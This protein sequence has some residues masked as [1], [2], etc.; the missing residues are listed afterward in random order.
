MNWQKF[1][2]GDVGLLR[3]QKRK[4]IYSESKIIPNVL[5][6]LILPNKNNKKTKAIRDSAPKALSSCIPVPHSPK[7]SKVSEMYF[8]NSVLFTNNA[9]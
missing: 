1:I 8:S 6:D 9:T 2:V 7:F 3:D 5:E 4:S